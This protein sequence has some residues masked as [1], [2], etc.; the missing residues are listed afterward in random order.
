M[1]NL[2][3]LGRT[4]PKP[5]AVIVVSPHWQTPVFAVKQAQRFSA[6]HDF[7]GFPA[8]LY[9]LFNKAYL[10]VA[11][12]YELLTYRHEADE[13]GDRLTATIERDPS[14]VLF[15]DRREGYRPR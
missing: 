3:G 10:A 2:V 7:S 9:A 4:L 1:G 6:W 11:D 13:N 15:G 8:E 5:R 12:P 14:R